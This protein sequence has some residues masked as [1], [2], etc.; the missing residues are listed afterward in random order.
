MAPPEALTVR[1]FNNTKVR[2]RTGIGLQAGG[3]RADERMR[4][5][6]LDSGFARNARPALKLDRNAGL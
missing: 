3:L 4:L 1:A 6:G 2:L 5:L